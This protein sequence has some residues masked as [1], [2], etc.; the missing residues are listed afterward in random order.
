MLQLWI[1]LMV[2]KRS[3]CANNFVVAGA[4]TSR[5]CAAAVCAWVECVDTAAGGLVIGVS[6][7]DGVGCE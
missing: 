6:W 5:G 7:V 3:H 2:C 4:N 1:W